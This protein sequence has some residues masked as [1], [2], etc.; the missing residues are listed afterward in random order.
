V[1]VSDRFGTYLV[2][3]P[4]EHIGF[5]SGQYFSWIPVFVSMT[6]MPMR[7]ESDYVKIKATELDGVVVSCQ[8]ESC[9]NVWNPFTGRDQTS[10]LVVAPAI[11]AFPRRGGYFK[12]WATPWGGS[13]SGS[14]LESI[15]SRCKTRSKIF[16]YGWGTGNSVRF[17]ALVFFSPSIRCDWELTP[18]SHKGNSCP[19]NVWW[20]AASALDIKIKEGYGQDWGWI[21]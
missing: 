20:R 9:R 8:D 5:P 18:L 10:P 19:A 21:T 3:I 11:P 7:G 12:A 16:Y 2:N 14:I 15:C 4:P 13:Q 1:L 6:C 17:H